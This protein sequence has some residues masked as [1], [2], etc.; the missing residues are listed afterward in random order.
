MEIKYESCHRH[1]LYSD[2]VDNFFKI[3]F[4]TTRHRQS[5]QSKQ[6]KISNQKHR[7]IQTNQIFSW[8]VCISGSCKPWKGLQ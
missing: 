1:M 6:S 3:E 7:Q 4:E 5:K 8:S 2:A